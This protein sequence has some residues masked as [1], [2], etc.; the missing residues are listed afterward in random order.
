[1]TTHF[2]S[3]WSVRKKNGNERIDKVSNLFKWISLWIGKNM[4]VSHFSCVHRKRMRENGREDQGGS[5]RPVVIFRSLM[6]F[7]FHFACLPFSFIAHSWIQHI[8]SQTKWAVWAEFIEF[9][10]VNTYTNNTSFSAAT[11]HN[12]GALCCECV[13]NMQLYM[14]IEWQAIDHAIVGRQRAKECSLPA[15]E[16]CIW[17]YVFLVNGPLLRNIRSI[18]SESHEWIDEWQTITGDLMAVASPS[19]IASH[20][21]HRKM[22]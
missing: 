3:A 17:N 2:I 16:L 19:H 21:A 9:K 20:G 5:G 10:E 8:H 1:M 4:N 18:N 7:V 14:C 13:I 11:S 6:L 12:T 22:Q 15:K